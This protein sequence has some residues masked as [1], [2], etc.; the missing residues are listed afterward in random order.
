MSNFV[1]A[2]GSLGN[3]KDAHGFQPVIKNTLEPRQL[4]NALALASAGIISIM[5]LHHF[6]N[7][8]LLANRSAAGLQLKQLISFAK[9]AVM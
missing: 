8:I 3:L 7:E 4:D 5:Q 2:F 9:G 6:I 1:S